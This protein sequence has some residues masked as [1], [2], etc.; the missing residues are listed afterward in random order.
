MMATSAAGQTRRILGEAAVVH[1][2]KYQQDN[3]LAMQLRRERRARGKLPAVNNLHQH[4]PCSSSVAAVFAWTGRVARSTRTSSS[5]AARAVDFLLVMLPRQSPRLL[6]S[7]CL[8][9]AQIMVSNSGGGAEQRRLPQ[10]SRGA[11]GRDRSSPITQIPP[12]SC[13]ERCQAD[14]GRSAGERRRG[15]D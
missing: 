6:P 14:G 12:R 4:L 10:A 5:G 2:W 11:A 7:R 3:P 13:G 15:G 1:L 9:C 8:V